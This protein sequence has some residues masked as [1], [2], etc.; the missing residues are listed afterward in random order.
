[1]KFIKLYCSYCSA[2]HLLHSF[3]ALSL[4]CHCS[5]HCGFVYLPV[6]V[7]R[8]DECH[9]ERNKYKKNINKQRT[10]KGVDVVQET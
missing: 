1:M 5:V 10:M 9:D 2:I 6:L 4:R 7:I 3:G 8:P